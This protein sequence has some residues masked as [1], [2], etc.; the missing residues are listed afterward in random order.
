MKNG[1]GVKNLDDKQIKQHIAFHCLLTE[2]R[3]CTLIFVCLNIFL[4]KYYTKLKTNPSLASY[5][6]YK[7]M[8]L[9]CVDFIVLLSQNI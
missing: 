4:Q 3:L 6:E 5:L 1:A 7:M 9:L 2:I 8:I